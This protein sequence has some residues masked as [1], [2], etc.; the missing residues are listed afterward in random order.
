MTHKKRKITVFF[1]CLFVLI[2][3]HPTLIY[4]SA[5]WPSGVSVKAEG[6]IL[7]DGDT[8]TVL[9]GQ[10]IHKTYFPASITKVMTALLVI[11][12]C[13]L[14]E[15]VTFSH[16]AVF[17][18]ESGSSNAGI[19]EGDKL[20]VKDCLYALL[21]KSANESANAL[22]E[23][24]AG[25][26][27]AFAD[28]MNARA[29]ELGCQN[30]HFANPSGLNNP[31]HYTSPYDMALIAKAAFENPVFE[32]IDSTTHYKLPPNSINKEGLSIHP[33]HKMIR[34]TPF[35]Y[36]G[37]IGGKT[38]YTTLAGNTLITCAQKNGMKLITIILKGTTPQYWTDTKNL[39]DFG[40]ENFVSLKAADYEKTYNSVT[41]DLN[42]SG[43]SIT[44]PEALILDPDSHIILPKTADFYDAHAELSYDISSDDPENAIA[45]INYRYNDRVVGNTFLMINHALFPKETTKKETPISKD[46][47]AK[48]AAEDVS[49]EKVLD[50]DT[51][52]SKEEAEAEAKAYREK[53]LRPFEIPLAAWLVLGGVGAIAFI[54][55]ASAF[56]IYRKHR[57]QQDYLIRREQR[58][59][60]LK[61]SGVSADEFNSI[62]E[63]RKSSYT[64]KKKGRRN[65]FTFR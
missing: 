26:R 20:S 29:K 9:W 25:S 65:H 2:S 47:G 3:A 42:F 63:Q 5:D 36:P 28:Q 48:E 11:E 50:K 53:A 51:K 39:L 27:E 19:N 6:A 58:M 24:V 15:T 4:A 43:L 40:F 10:N 34:K 52:K 64:S 37:V 45:K 33:G 49:S 35:Y 18:V 46:G 14:D 38:G 23:H 32:E 16:D 57:E 31:E 30:T 22:A 12:N 41:S 56:F 44:K 60:R 55:G 17:N 21:L 7:I 61:D 1:L 54:G 13:N 62:L 59:R 8:G